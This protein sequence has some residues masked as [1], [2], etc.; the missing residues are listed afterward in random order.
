MTCLLGAQALLG[1][2]LRKRDSKKLTKQKTT[3]GSVA[4][5]TEPLRKLFWPTPSMFSNTADG[6][7]SLVSSI[8]KSDAL[9][10]IDV[11]GMSVAINKMAVEWIPPYRSTSTQ[12]ETLRSQ[13]PRARSQ[14]N[15]P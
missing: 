8:C 5:N 3:S 10:A 12:E 7:L 14:V 1:C 6:A 15:I 2:Y 13:L 9:S 11:I 4:S